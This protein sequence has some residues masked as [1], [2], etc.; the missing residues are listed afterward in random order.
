MLRRTLIVMAEAAVCAGFALVCGCGGTADAPI[1]TV[2]AGPDGRVGTGVPGPDAGP[3]APHDASTAGGDA[4]DDGSPGDDGP[5]DGGGGDSG[6]MQTKSAKIDLLFDIDNSASMG[7]KEAYL[8]RAIPDLVTRLV[9]PNCVDAA[10]NPTGTAADAA[11]HCASGAPEFKPVRDMHI[12][13]VSSSLGPRLGNV[14]PRTGALGTQVLPNGSTLDRHN[15]DQGHLLSRASDPA[16]LTNY[17]EAPAADTGTSGF[18]DWAPTPS[19]G[20]PAITDAARLQTDLQ[21]MVIGVHAFGCGIESQLESWY[22]FLIQPDPY[23]SLALDANREAQWQGVDTVLL[24]Q[25]ADF[26]RPDSLVA[27][28][29]VSD[30]N[31]SEVDVRSFNGT[32]WNFM[33]TSFDPPRGTSA[34]ATDAN[35]AACTSCGFSGTTNTTD[36]ACAMG[37]YKSLNDWGY[38]LNLRHVHEKEKYGVSVQFPIQR[39]VLGLTSRQVPDRSGEY[40]AGG[41]GMYAGLAAASHDCTNPLFAAKLPSPPPGVD[42][43]QWQPTAAELC[44]LTPGTRGLSLVYY[45]HIG[46][47]PHQLLQVDPTNPSSPQKV[48]LTAA[49]WTLILGKDPLAYD[50][51]GIDPHMIESYQPRTGA[52]VP[53]GG[54]SVADSSAAEGADPISGREWITDSTMAQHNGLNVDREYACTFK[55]PA[56]RDCSTAATNADPTLLDSCDCMSPVSG[57]G[58]FTHAQ[59]PAVCNDATP[60]QQDYA[61]AYPTIRELLLAQQLGEVDGANQGVVS[62]LCPIHS[63]PATPNDPLY[64]YRPAMA[65][66]VDRLRNSL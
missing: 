1:P 24:A 18:L 37:P 53:D 40:P 34:C 33:D 8:T 29:V 31:D 10:G 15:D 41:S 45:S 2:D 59:V 61:K 25:R 66:I 54:F 16:N 65:A 35:S 62:S 56:P 58:A 22:R 64:G 14:C 63:V 48:H 50:Y 19:A 47:V 4:G 51:T 44:N 23:A 57:T 46:G 32:G 20:A 30:E 52:V 49:D 12:G 6:S 13:I 26:L 11:G 17:A 38:D 60:T 9:S 3:G 43:S 42:P 39:Y 28:I 21:G 55:L 27:V 5:G 36:P 7:D